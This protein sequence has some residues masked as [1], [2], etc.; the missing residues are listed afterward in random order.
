MIQWDTFALFETLLSGFRDVLKRAKSVVHE[1]HMSLGV[2]A[3]VEGFQMFQPVTAWSVEYA[4][5]IHR[6]PNEGLSDEALDWHEECATS[7]ATFSCFA[8]GTLLGKFAKGDIDDAGFLSGEAYLPGFVL[9][10][11][12]QICSVYQSDQAVAR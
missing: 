12:E 2:A 4:A 3:A 5:F 1:P 11:E 6:G 9:L 8:L 10:N 7:V